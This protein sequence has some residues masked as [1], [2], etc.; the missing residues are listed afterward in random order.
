[1]QQ[2]SLWCAW[3]DSP[4]WQDASMLAIDQLAIDQ[5]DFSVAHGSALNKVT[6]VGEA[7]KGYSLGCYVCIRQSAWCN[8]IAD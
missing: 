7:M 3:E 1:M 2:R 8:W 6:L 5:A 4:A